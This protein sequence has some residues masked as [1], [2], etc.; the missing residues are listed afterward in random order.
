M[1]NLIAKK[2]A[3]A[4]MESSD[5]KEISG[6]L[7]ILDSLAAAFEDERVREIVNSPLV[8]REDK[9]EIFLS[10]LGKNPAATLENLIKLMG[11]KGRLDLLPEL[12]S[13]I[14]FEQKKAA[15]SYEGVL[16]S[17]ETLSDD[18]IANLEKSLEKYSGAKIKLSQSDSDQPGMK[19]T[20]DDLG[21]ELSFSRE[22]VK[23]ALIDYI[24]KA[25]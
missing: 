22:R 13:I 25:L 24:Q 6:Y 4:L 3:K 14:Q 5:K 12:V 18:S 8:S 16:V 1:S 11:Q 19:V 23:Q 9:I 21:I 20:V 15:N 10:A 17:D 2:Y 7:D